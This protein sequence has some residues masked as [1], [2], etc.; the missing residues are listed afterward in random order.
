V[1]K[2]PSDLC[3][4]PPTPRPS[5]PSPPN[6][7]SLCASVS[8]RLSFRNFL[9]LFLY[10]VTYLSFGTPHRQELADFNLA[11]FRVPPHTF[12]SLCSP[13]AS[14]PSSGFVNVVT[15]L[16]FLP[17]KRSLR[18]IILY[19]APIYPS[20]STFRVLT[21]HLLGSHHPLTPS[22]HSSPN[23]LLGLE[24]EFFS[25]PQINIL[26]FFSVPFT[27]CNIDTK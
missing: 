9:S 10:H 2:L 21:Q 24:L 5:P 22:L 23:P 6:D 27:N 7:K 3:F 20:E 12:H 17:T 15:P 14:H 1:L 26:V 13:K 11:I 8:V 4:N 19:S 25:S 16:L 18:P